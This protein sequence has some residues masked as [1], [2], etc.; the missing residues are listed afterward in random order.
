MDQVNPDINKENK[1]EKYKI[2]IHCA[3]GVSRSGAT[4]IACCIARGLPQNDRNK[5]K[6]I[7]KLIQF[8]NCQQLIDAFIIDNQLI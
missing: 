3:A 5:H 6:F 1:N 7:K 8:K 4:I 2:L